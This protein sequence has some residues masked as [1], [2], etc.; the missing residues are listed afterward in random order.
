MDEVV[1]PKTESINRVKHEEKHITLYYASLK[2]V[3]EPRW[4]YRKEGAV[5]INKD[6]G[7]GFY[8]SPDK[9]YPIRLYCMNDG[10]YI[11]RYSLD[12]SGLK[13]LRLENDI[14]WLLVTA[15]HRRDYSGFK[16]YHH[17][18][19]KIREW[20]SGF[21]LIIGTISN[22]NFYST[23]NAFIRNLISD[24][25]ALQIVQIMNYG[26]QYVLKSDKAC[27]QIEYL[28]SEQV[29]VQELE[30]HRT[31]K[32]VERDAME[33]MVEDM[34]VRIHPSDNGKLFAQIVEEVGN[35]VGTWF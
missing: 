2:T 5:K 28:D 9:E 8:A 20:V 31:A 17:L 30:K 10:V 23:V 1:Q 32:T 4:N 12:T 34:R 33:E 6:F 35:S 16:K 7:E 29:D 13:V 15:F 22:D 14:K 19:D 27:G 21:D 11:N 26:E 25:M 3:R 18:R 24:T